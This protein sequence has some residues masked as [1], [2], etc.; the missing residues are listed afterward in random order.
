MPF[1]R[2]EL[3]AH[4]AKP[5]E[6]VPD[7][8]SPFS[9]EVPP[10]ET[11]APAADDPSVTPESSG[12]DDPGDGASGT[13]DTP[14]ETPTD[15]SVAPSDGTDP[16]AAA[17]KKGSAAERI[18]ELVGERDDYKAYGEYA[19]EQIAARERELAELR[20]RLAT[21][22]PAAAAPAPAEEPFPKMEDPELQ[23]DPERSQARVS[24]W[25]AKKAAREAAVL[26][27]KTAAP[28]Q[29]TPQQRQQ[30]EL[31]SFGSRVQ[32]YVKAHPDF[33]TVTKALPALGAEAAV[34]VVRS[35]DGPALLYHLGH[36]KAEAVR[37]ARLDPL[38]QVLEMGA[39]RTRLA[40]Q[41]RSVKPTSTT[42]APGA[43]QTQAKPKVPSSAPTPPSRVTGGGTRTSVD[44]TDP[45]LSMAEFARRHREGRLQNRAQIRQARGLR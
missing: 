28:T 39:L 33:E 12:Q 22:A 37:I 41:E 18:Q 45:S 23:S 8:T 21:A 27:A 6:V 42:P 19:Q 40:S 16:A 9:D 3:A 43:S 38:Q 11:P 13:G 44:I 1:T 26:A 36:H 7:E 4:E 20:A 32:E 24:E 10:V 15:T 35:E 17:P 30:R 29:E 31:Q 5:A 34:A 25:A 2:E 14:S